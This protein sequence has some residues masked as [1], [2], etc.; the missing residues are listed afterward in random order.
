MDC[1]VET[2]LVGNKKGVPAGEFVGG[3][4]VV[5]WS[6]GMNLLV[7]AGL[8][9]KAKRPASS[10]SLSADLVFNFDRLQVQACRH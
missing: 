1:G 7:L 2:S 8:A 4:V 3:W 10:S 6:L 5:C 9:S